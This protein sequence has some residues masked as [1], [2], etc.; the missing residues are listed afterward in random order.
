MLINIVDTERDVFVRC[1][2]SNEEAKTLRASLPPKVEEAVDNVAVVELHVIH[3][4]IALRLRRW[5]DK[6]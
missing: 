3:V 2:L 4:T 6:I 5:S 1:I